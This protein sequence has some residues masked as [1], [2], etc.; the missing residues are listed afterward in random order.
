MPPRHGYQ[1]KQILQHQRK[2]KNH[3]IL[4]PEK[5]Y[6]ERMKELK[7]LPF[8]LDME[9]HDILMLL[10]MLN[11]KYDVVLNETLPHAYDPT[12]KFRRE[13]LPIAQTRLQKDR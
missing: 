10:V 3:W 1:T 4:G 6:Y 9:I 2:F 8:S 5:I 12:R 7:L 13:E 11:D